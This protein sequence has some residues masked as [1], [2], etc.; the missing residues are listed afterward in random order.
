MAKLAD[1]PALG[2][3]DRKVVEVQILLPAQSEPYLSFGGRKFF[4]HMKHIIKLI[5]ISFLLSIIGNWL[6]FLTGLGLNFSRGFVCYQF[7]GGPYLCSFLEAAFSSLTTTVFVAL[8][9]FGASIFIPT[10]IIFFLF[11][12]YNR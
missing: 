3:G 2:A 1:A 8:F 5:F 11:Y 6:Y 10:A 12:F 7:E 9:S 4:N